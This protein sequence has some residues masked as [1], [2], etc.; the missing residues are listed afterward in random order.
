[1]CQCSRRPGSIC[2]L[3]REQPCSVAVHIYLT[4]S[5]L[6]VFLLFVAVSASSYRCLTSLRIFNVCY[7][8]RATLA[9][10]NLFLPSKPTPPFISFYAP[11]SLSVL[12]TRYCQI[13]SFKAHLFLFLHV[14]ISRYEVSSGFVKSLVFS[15]TGDPLLSV[16]FAL[17]ALPLFSSRSTTKKITFVTTILSE[18]VAHGK[19]GSRRSFHSHS[20]ART[21]DSDQVFIVFC[22][23]YAKL[24]GLPYSSLVHTNDDVFFTLESSLTSRIYAWGTRLVRVAGSA[25]IIT[26]RSGS[27]RHTSD[28]GASKVE[29]DEVVMVPVGPSKKAGTAR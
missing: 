10:L 21:D 22:R 5:E 28:S 13:A 17:K 18:S 8:L 12:I 2:S 25:P 23:T 1:M 4:L 20:L 24:Q 6:E 26:P 14:S 7:R 15:R 19:N 11:G 16:A 3:R 29:H 27:A 9:Q